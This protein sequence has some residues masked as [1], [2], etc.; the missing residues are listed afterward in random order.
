MTVYRAEPLNDE[1]CQD[2]PSPE[3]LA[4]LMAKHGP[5]ATYV[6]MDTKVYGGGWMGETLMEAAK[7]VLARRQS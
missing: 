1:D 5:E 4:N 2:Y 3:A 6:Y 7:A